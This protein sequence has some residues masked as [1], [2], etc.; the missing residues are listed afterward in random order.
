M[1]KVPINEGEAIIETYFGSGAT[2][3]PKTGTSILNEYTLKSVPADLA[4][5]GLVD[6]KTT[7]CAVEL[8]LKKKTAEECY[9]EISRPCQISIREYDELRIFGAVGTAIVMRVTAV[10]DGKEQVLIEEYKGDSATTEMVGSISGEVLESLTMRFQM[11]EDRRSMIRLSWIG[12]A[13]AA[14]VAEMTAR[15]TPYEPE[16]YGYMY[17]DDSLVEYKPRLGIMFG[18]EEMEAIRRKVQSGYLKQVFEELRA[19]AEEDMKM[20]PEKCIGTY[21]PST[22]HRW[23]RVRDRGRK[24]FQEPMRRL[25]FVGLVDQNPDMCRMAVRI[26]LSAAHCTYWTESHMGVFPGDSWHHRSFLEQAYCTSC[27]FVLDWCGHF[28]TPYGRN[29]IEDAII[30]KGLPRIESDFKRH[31]YIKHMNQ[32]IVFSAGR[33]IGMLS[34]VKRYPGYR[35]LIEEAEADLHQMIEE[36]V[37]SDGGVAEGMGYW[38]YTFATCMPIF[39]ALSRFHG[40]SFQEYAT[41]SLLKTAKYAKDNVSIQNGGCCMINVNDAE[42]MAYSEGVLAAFYQLT[43]DKDFLDL[44]SVSMAKKVKSRGDM[45]IMLILI[46][47]NMEP[48]DRYIRYGLFDYPETGFTH[49]VQ[50]GE[51]FDTCLY[52]ISGKRESG[53][54]HD[55]KGSFFLETDKEGFCI[56]RGKTEYSSVESVVMAQ[57]G[58]HNVFYPEKPDG[59]PSVQKTESQSSSS[60]EYKDGV[61]CYYTDTTSAWEDGL[62]KHIERKISSE[63]AEEF[64]IEDCAELF[65]AM[66]MSFRVNTT[67]PVVIEKDGARIIGQYQDVW[68][69]PMWDAEITV[70]TVGV[71]GDKEPVNLIRLVSPSAVEHK[72]VTKIQVLTKSEV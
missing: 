38:D 37:L 2:R 8:D 33:I 14:R 70:E 58:Y 19:Q 43:L 59:S 63:K 41:L 25:G 72:T 53:H 22:D 54:G 48:V 50:K 11:I 21:A 57:A 32:G 42:T 67:L 12:L 61:F 27:A 17:Q 9:V 39:S 66:P 71:N 56:D 65:E 3:D 10:I 7:W 46:P 51:E 55:D 45:D 64:V 35:T 30:M 13:N 15:P 49:I 1:R 16:W 29:A 40:K 44:M 28:L 18:E 24:P 68:I 20:E 47:E 62:F 60:A 69:Q 52:A 31:E 34:V 5:H 23:I 6:F 36:Y 4:E 26:A